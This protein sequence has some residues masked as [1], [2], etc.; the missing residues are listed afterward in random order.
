MKHDSQFDSAWSRRRIFAAIVGA[1]LLPLAST[2]QAAPTRDLMDIMIETGTF[3]AWLGAVRAS[4]M[5]ETLRDDGPFTVFAPT[6]DAVR[7][8]PPGRMAELMRPENRNRL[9]ELVRRHIV[10]QRIVARDIAGIRLR[11][12]TMSDRSL[13]LDG[14]GGRLVLDDDVDV[15]SADIVASNGVIHIVRNVIAPY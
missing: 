12:E 9:A 4:G 11:V 13:T 2:A 8:M 7:D 15:L 6:D 14:T 1:I 3:C 10:P 5:E